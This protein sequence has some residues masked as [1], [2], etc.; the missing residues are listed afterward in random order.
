MTDSK[1]IEYLKIADNSLQTFWDQLDRTDQ[2]R[3]IIYALRGI[4]GQLIQY[5]E[6]GY[7]DPFYVNEKCNLIKLD[8]L[9]IKN[10]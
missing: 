10:E 7:F 6:G 1:T 5:N 8:C 4:L 3:P 9:G 2:Q